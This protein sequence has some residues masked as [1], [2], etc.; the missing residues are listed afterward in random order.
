MISRISRYKAF[1]QSHLVRRGNKVW[2]YLEFTCCWVFFIIIKI[3]IK[4]NPCFS[5]F[6]YF[7]CFLPWFSILRYN[8]LLESMSWI[9]QKKTSLFIWTFGIGPCPAWIFQKKKRKQKN[10]RIYLIRKERKTINIF[11]L[12]H[13]H[14]CDCSHVHYLDFLNKLM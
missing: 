4:K 1:N 12:W 11:Q 3:I 10:F 6:F 9:S 2:L 8:E 7:L 5:V 14:C 13:L